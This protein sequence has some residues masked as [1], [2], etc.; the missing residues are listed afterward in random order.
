MGGLRKLR[1][2]IILKSCMFRASQQ[3][4]GDIRVSY[5][6]FCSDD[7]KSLL[8][9]TCLKTR[10]ILLFNDLTVLVQRAAP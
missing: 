8:D 3:I 1:N 6:G 4:G 9:K 10:K 2:E 5:R 7:P